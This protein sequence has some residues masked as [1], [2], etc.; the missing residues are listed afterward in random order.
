MRS[1]GSL[2]MH[3][4]SSGSWTLLTH[5]WRFRGVMTFFYYILHSARN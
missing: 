1:I 4:Y 3:E 2:P 5:G